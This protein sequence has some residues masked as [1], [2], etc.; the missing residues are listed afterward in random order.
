MTN[1]L[2]VKL[3][4]EL[5]YASVKGGGNSNKSDSGGILSKVAPLKFNG[6]FNDL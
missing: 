6:I 4:G 1:M 5:N 2:H 3:G